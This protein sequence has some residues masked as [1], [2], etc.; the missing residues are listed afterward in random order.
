MTEHK[1]HWKLWNSTIQK[2]N[3]NLGRVE[4]KNEY[5]CECGATEFRNPTKKQLESIGRIL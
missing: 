4:F 2:F 3:E 1:H 5:R